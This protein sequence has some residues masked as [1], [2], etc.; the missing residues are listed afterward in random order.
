[1]KSSTLSSLYHADQIK[2]NGIIL[3]ESRTNKARLVYDHTP[4]AFRG[5]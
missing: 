3:I 5:G 1:M 2:E 4:T